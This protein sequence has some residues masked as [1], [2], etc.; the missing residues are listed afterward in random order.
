VNYDVFRFVTF[1]EVLG[2]VARRMVDMAF[3][4]HIGNNFLED[5]H[6]NSPRFRVPRNVVASFERLGHHKSTLLRRLAGDCD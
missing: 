2:V 1:N 5:D 3:E 4:P 6:T